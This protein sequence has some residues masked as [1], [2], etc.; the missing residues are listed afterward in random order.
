MTNYTRGDVILVDVAFS[1][2]IG[3]KPARPSRS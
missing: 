2:T 3:Y 1:G